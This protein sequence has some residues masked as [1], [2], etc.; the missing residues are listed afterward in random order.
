MPYVRLDRSPVIPSESPVEI[1]YREWGAGPPLILLH[2]GWGY[3]IYNFD[4]QVNAFSDRFRMIAPD[5]TGY[6]RS[7]RL[8]ELPSGFHNAAAEETFLTLD[9]LGIQQAI[10]W[11]HSDGAVIA[12]IMGLTRPERV[13]GVIL[14]AFHFERNKAGSKHFFEAM[15]AKPE[16]FG[17]RVSSVLAQDHGDGYWRTVLRAGGLAWLRIIDESSDPSKDFYGGHLWELAVPAI[18]IHGGQDPRTEPGELAAVRSTLPHCPVNVIQAARH[19]PHSSESSFA[20]CNVIAEEFLS[21][22]KK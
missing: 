22:L 7:N 8:P 19:S 1:Y 9:Q 17:D 12:A 10:L 5:R 15:V 3:E 4:R 11:G 14:E 16:E 6:G 2:G 21:R 18:F 13:R 20:E